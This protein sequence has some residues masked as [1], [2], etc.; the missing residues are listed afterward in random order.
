MNIVY[1]LFIRVGWLF[2][3]RK[4]FETGINAAKSPAARSSYGPDSI[5]IVHRIPSPQSSTT[6]GRIHE[7]VNFVEF[8]GHCLSRRHTILLKGSLLLHRGGTGYQDWCPA[9]S[10]HCRN[11]RI[12]SAP[13]PPPFTR[14]LWRLPFTF[15]IILAKPSLLRLFFIRIAFDS[16]PVH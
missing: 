11:T 8:S 7:S 10:R 15:S 2:T 9:G 3:S 14:R 1:P 16:H 4:S 6:H 13:G 5:I 12:A